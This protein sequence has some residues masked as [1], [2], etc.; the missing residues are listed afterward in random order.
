MYDWDILMQNYGDGA[1]VRMV[2]KGEIHETEYYQP[3]IQYP[4]KA[5]AAI[6]G[7]TPKMLRVKM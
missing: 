7:K 6:I 5:G 1:S 2:T 4:R 3:G